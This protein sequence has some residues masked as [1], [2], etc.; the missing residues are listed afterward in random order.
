MLRASCLPTWCLLGAPGHLRARS[1]ESD[2]GCGNLRRRHLPGFAREGA[3][4]HRLDHRCV[5]DS[6]GPTRCVGQGHLPRSRTER[7]I[8]S[9]DTLH[10]WRRTPPRAVL[11]CLRRDNQYRR[12][13][14]C[15]DREGRRA[16][17]PS[18][19]WRP[20]ASCGMCRTRV[21]E[22]DTA[23]AVAH[24]SHRNSPWNGVYPGEK[25]CACHA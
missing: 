11:A 7:R 4:W 3:S 13:G 22:D 14:H 1:P 18:P 2:S 15:G 20:A 10:T 25:M 19:A 12:V 16:W 5:S 21:V 17:V 9:C 23:W 24:G 6:A 8:G